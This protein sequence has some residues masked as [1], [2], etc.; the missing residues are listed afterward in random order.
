[1]LDDLNTAATLVNL[2]HL[3][4]G[5]FRLADGNE[6]ERRVLPAHAG[7]VRNLG[8]LLGLLR[9][10]PA[11]WFRGAAAGGDA[12][13]ESLIAARLAA[14]KARNFAEADRIRDELKAKGVV[15]EDGPGGTTWRRTG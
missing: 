11:E 3:A 9:H 6:E 13:I 14:R 7:E 2:D 12:E 8:E 5:V 1:L 15:L 4:D 10:T